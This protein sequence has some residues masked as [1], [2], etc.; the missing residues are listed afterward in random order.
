MIGPIPYPITLHEDSI[1]AISICNNST[2]KGRVKHIELK[3]LK[4]K[5]YFRNNMLKV[6]KVDSKTNQQLADFLTKRLNE[7]FFNH[8]I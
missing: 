4:T 2:S 8:K 6:S 5:E 7:K 3:Y 1:A